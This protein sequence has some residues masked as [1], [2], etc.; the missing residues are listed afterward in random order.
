MPGASS[1][2]LSFCWEDGRRAGFAT[3]RLG[4]LAK[5]DVVEAKRV[6]NGDEV[7][8]GR[9]GEADTRM[10]VE[11]VMGP[12]PVGGAHMDHLPAARRSAVITAIFQKHVARLGQGALDIKGRLPQ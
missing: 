1:E 2:Q 6:A 3:V 11:L 9:V 12:D 7:L 8:G 5:Q 10:E 4:M